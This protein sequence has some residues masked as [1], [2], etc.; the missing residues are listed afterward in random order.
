MA[1]PLGTIPFALLSI[2]TLVLLYH[3]VYSPP[4][5]AAFSNRNKTHHE[6]RSIRPDE[7]RKNLWS[8]LTSVEAEG[9]RVW[10]HQPEQGLNLTPSANATGQ[11]NAVQLFEILRPNKTDV[12]PY[13]SDNGA[14]P[15]RYAR[16]TIDH[17]SDP[18]EAS[19]IDEYMVGP[20]PIGEATTI[21]PLTYIYNSGRHRTKSR[22]SLYPA[23]QDWLIDLSGEIEDIAHDLFNFT[24]GP[25]GKPNFVAAPIDP[26]W[27]EDDLS[28]V[29]I[30]FYQNTL[31]RS[32]LHQALHFKL[33][34][35]SRKASEWKILEWL[36]NGVLYDDL[37]SF[38]AAWKSPGFVKLPPN[39]GGRWTD[40][41]PMDNPTG[42]LPPPPKFH[43]SGPSRVFVD[44]AENFVSWLN[45]TFTVSFSQITAVSLFDIRIDDERVFYELGFQE[46]MA[47]YAGDDPKMSGTTYLDT[48]FGFGA[49]LAELV[50]GYDCPDYA[51]Y[52]DTEFHKEEKTFHR[53]NTICI[54]EK[55]MDYPIQR[56]TDAK[57]TASFI[58]TTLIVRSIATIG[59]YD[60]LI[61]YSFYV[62]G[63]VEVKVRASGYI[64][65][66]YALHNQFYGYKVR[67][68]LS[69]AMHDHVLNFKADLDIG[70][71]LSNTFQ[72][73]DI[74]EKEI[75]YPWSPNNGSR[76]T[77]T[78]APSNITSE[79]SGSLVWPPNSNA[80]Y[81]ISSPSTNRWG[82]TRSYRIAPGT[83]IGTPAHLTIRNSSNLLEAAR[84]AE[85]DIYITRQHDTEP[86]S[87]SPLNG[88]TPEDP[89]VR[90]RDF[91]ADNETL[92]NEDLVVWFNLGSHHVPNSADIPNTVMTTSSSSVMFMPFNFWD[93]DRSMQ[94]AKGVRVDHP[95]G[96]G[97][98]WVSTATG[99]EAGSDAEDV[100]YWEQTSD[101]DTVDA[102]PREDLRH[103]S[104]N[105][106]GNPG[107]PEHSGGRRIDFYGLRRTEEERAE[108]LERLSKYKGLRTGEM[109]EYMPI[110][111][112]IE[113]F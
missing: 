50:P 70:G 38:R 35:T 44:K 24:I 108:E 23:F 91:L 16:V 89:L 28:V 71:H 98:H 68:T 84:W 46:A 79:S 2:W 56:H 82:E 66:A 99:N 4:A 26:F 40:L 41:R 109:R 74:T 7:I 53:K 76:R 18:A 47:H 6:Y 75:T 13:L 64:Q 96:D 5:F 11:D 48:S 58:S 30:G 42:D 8:E 32:L 12:V 100:G 25:D 39:L 54:F 36:Y 55:P 103:R 80:F 87:C 61:D 112:D 21:E 94:W 22:D 95:E 17:G 29:W 10:L 93:R 90:F 34:I 3:Q 107:S 52:L 31:A 65:G 15:S 57:S 14:E 86:R 102:S 77:M 33:D 110:D 81:L 113:V 97:V 45:F 92:E 72:R 20:L 73:V 101:R 78:L 60:Y 49:L 111:R 1:V 88:F 105:K 62:D 83:G 43:L 37:G 67:D 106:D 51:E 9:L 85:H 69:T 19:T 59:N 104:S 27:T 63:G